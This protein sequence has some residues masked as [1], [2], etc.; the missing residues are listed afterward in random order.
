M[1]VTAVDI[2]QLEQFADRIFANVGIDVEFTNHFKDRVNSERNQK[3]IVPAELT[4]LFKQE[5]KRYGKPIAQ[6]G[7]DSEAVMRDLQTDINVP[8]A[9]VLDKDNN[10]LDLIAKTIMRK[11][12]FSTPNRVFAVE[13]SPFRIGTRYEMPRKS[14]RPL[15]VIEETIVLNN[16]FEG[17]DADAEIYVDMDGVLAD[18][19][20]EWAR[21][22]DKE[23]WRD[24]KDVSPALAKIRATDNFWLNLPIL[25]QAKKLLAMIKQVKGEYNICTSPLAD[26]PNSI[27]HKREWI[28]KNLSFFPPKNVYI[29]HN[30]PQ[31]ATNNNGTPN[32]LIDDY[33]VNIDAWE[34]AG[35]IGIKHNDNKFERTKKALTSQQAVTE[36]ATKKHPKEPGAY[37]MTHNG[38]E[39]KIS[40]HLDDNDIHRGEWDIFS[41]GVSAFSGDKWE[42]VDTV[43]QRW[44]AIARVKG[45]SENTEKDKIAFNW[46]QESRA[47]RTPRQLNGLKQ[48]QLGEQLFEQLLALQILANSDPVY[49][50]RIAED[51]MKLQNWPG[52]RTSQ[53]DLYNV[54]A[55]MMK[56]NKFKDRVAQD[57][58]VTIPELR[59]KRNFRL[60]AKRDFNNSDYSY[61]MLMLQRAMVDFLPA[62]LI[63]MRRQIANWNNIVPRDKNV[64]RDRLMLQMRKSG[65]QNE[66][67]EFL[68]RTKIFKRR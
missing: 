13:D 47:Y 30:K 35:G 68:R 41:K 36:G 27:P 48:S 32:I 66:F 25:P 56:P 9:L 33:G 16:I 63:Q 58:T 15:P 2:Q 37:L 62:P 14:I 29:T 52:F 3:P 28:E 65:L 6:M 60:I 49:A 19:F 61:L 26:D 59:L 7:P 55:I 50:A 24:I 10:E 18:F 5:R 40:R 23:N 44:N 22:M 12:D 20:G 51:I 8:F 21:L 11:K 64:I 34:A 53:P 31:Y 1:S 45:L 54:I 4:R 43:S 67:Y 42:W 17:I 57:V 46:L 38:I 39:Y